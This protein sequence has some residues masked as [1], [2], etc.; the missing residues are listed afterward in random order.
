MKSSTRPVALALAFVLTISM[1][2]G[3]DHL[4]QTEGAAP[5]AMAQ[6]SAP[7]A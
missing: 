4:A 1:L 3:I 6:A 2:V 7:R 5:A